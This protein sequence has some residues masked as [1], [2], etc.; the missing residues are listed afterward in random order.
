MII[1]HDAR[2]VIATPTKCGKTTIESMVRRSMTADISRN[3]EVVRPGQHRLDCPEQ[4]RGYVRYM[5][6]RDPWRRLLS[7]WS[8]LANPKS[9]GEHRAKEIQQLS[10]A[11]FVEWWLA[12]RTEYMEWQV[13]WKELPAAGLWSAPA[14]WLMT[15]KECAEVWHPD[16]LINVEDL[17]L[18]LKVRDLDYGTEVQNNSSER[19]RPGK[20]TDYYDSEMWSVVGDAFAQRDAQFIGQ[21][22]HPPSAP[23]LGRYRNK[24]LAE[25][26]ELV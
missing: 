17:Q 9:K 12:Y 16:G 1:D 13:P 3:L 2:I 5:M 4:A 24:T 14:R 25:L 21:T 20:W 19:V 8:F 26:K 11:Q 6:V 7:Q 23:G 10:F 18:E 15:L 22:V